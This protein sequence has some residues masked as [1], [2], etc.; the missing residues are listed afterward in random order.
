MKKILLGGIASLFLLGAGC[1]SFSSSGP[2][3]LGV[4][5]SSDKGEK[6]QAINVL[7][8]AQGIKTIGGA[9]TYRIF[10]DPND[11]KTLYLATRGQGLFYSLDRGDSWQAISYFN[12]KFIYGVSVDPLNKCT[13]YVTDASTISKTEDCNRTWRTVYTTQASKIIGIAV[14]YQDPNDVY[15]ALENGTVLKS[16]NKGESWRS[17]RTFR[18]IIREIVTDP[19]TPGRIFV[20]T[21]QNGMSRSDDGG[22]NWESAS[23]GLSNFS[24]ALTFNRFVL[25]AGRKDSIYWVSKYGI[26]HST[27][28]GRNW[29]DLKLVTSPGSINIYSFA[30]NPKNSNE[31]YYTGTTY[32]NQK[33]QS[34]SKLYRST[35][36]GLT[37][38]N[39]KL[40]TSAIPVH[41]IINPENGNT[42]FMGF[43][44]L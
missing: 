34:V 6:W 39:R 37:W 4:Y 15:A 35:D 13:V 3:T 12:S 11:S 38:V 9:K 1:I 42:L 10:A 41:M 31:M 36:G 5:R 14:E 7:P 19:M 27:D 32:G 25:D 29:T 2:A 26:F 44:T 23:N 16:S 22:V 43:T 20:A 30:V 18:G 24:E 33:G 17:I 21:A 8:T 40:P 28:A